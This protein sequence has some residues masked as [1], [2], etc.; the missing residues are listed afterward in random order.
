MQMLYQTELNDRGAD[1]G[2]EPQPPLYK[3]GA[4]P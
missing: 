4:L 1:S 3:G 2:Y